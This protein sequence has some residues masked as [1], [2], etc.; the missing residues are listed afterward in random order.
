MTHRTH[1]LMAFLDVAHAIL[2][3]HGD[4]SEEEQTV[5]NPQKLKLPF[6]VEQHI[7]EWEVQTFENEDEDSNNKMEE[8]QKFFFSLDSDNVGC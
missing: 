2:K 7:K 1:K 6:K 4:G 8:M 3:K 5:G